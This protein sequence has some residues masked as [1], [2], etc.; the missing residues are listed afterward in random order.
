[1]RQQLELM[2]SVA[3]SQQHLLE[4]YP[5]L[6]PNRQ[7]DSNM[8]ATARVADVQYWMHDL[9]QVSPVTKQPYKAKAVTLHM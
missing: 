7:F 6:L 2:S 8:E 9:M 3:S 4:M 1:M 5:N